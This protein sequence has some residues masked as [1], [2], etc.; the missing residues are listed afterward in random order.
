MTRKRYH[1]HDEQLSDDLSANMVSVQAADRDYVAEF[2]QRIG[3]RFPVTWQS[4]SRAEPVIDTEEVPET[5]TESDIE[6]VLTSMK[7]DDIL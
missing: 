3:V 5:I 1:Y 6:D 2:Y 4:V 7:D